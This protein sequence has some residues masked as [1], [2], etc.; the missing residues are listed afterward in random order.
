MTEATAIKNIRRPG[1]GSLAGHTANC[2]NR[3]MA[4]W[5]TSAKQRDT[6]DPSDRISSYAIDGGQC[7]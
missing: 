1:D 3:E 7:L 6:D 4:P 2:G 5:V